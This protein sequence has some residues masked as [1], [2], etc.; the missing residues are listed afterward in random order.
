MAAVSSRSFP[1]SHRAPS[2]R[3]S[4]HI[5]ESISGSHVQATTML[6]TGY[7]AW[8]MTCIALLLFAGCAGGS[9]VSGRGTIRI[10]T[11]NIHHAV[12]TDSA[13]DINSISDVI[14][15]SNAD[16]VALQDVDRGVGRTKKLDMMTKLADLTGMTYT[17]G[18]SMDLD[19]GEHGNGLLTK[20]PILEER[21]LEYH[22]Q[23]S[24]QKCSLMELVLDI[25]GTETAFM[26]T[27]L[28]EESSDTLQLSNVAEIL[29]AASAYQN[30]PVIVVGSL[31]IA[32]ESKNISALKTG[33]QDSWTLAGS[34]N[35]FTYPSN[36]PRNRYDY[37]FVPNRKV[38]TDSKS[39]EVSLQPV[40][41][42]VIASNA[43]DH[44]PL[45]VA[46]KVV[47]E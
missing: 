12:G 44:L 34:G 16:I 36:D 19:G 28:N 2:E 37:I 22:L 29:S 40:E 11:Y 4:L 24:N 25:R 9:Q 1:D 43:S 5:I 13:F 30:T 38:P 23:S 47:S 3:P 41:S 14:T 17:F 15:H 45:L 10:M 32:P 7:L 26:N 6:S 21:L 18:K 20:F 31:N 33:F 42:I 39:L 35:G 27:E 46:L 8:T